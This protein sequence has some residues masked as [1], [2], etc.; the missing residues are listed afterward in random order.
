MVLMDGFV[1][2]SNGLVFLDVSQLCLWCMIE[3]S[4]ENI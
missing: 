2:H 3:S 1:C 4:L